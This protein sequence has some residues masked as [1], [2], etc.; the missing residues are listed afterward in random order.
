[1]GASIAPSGFIGQQ[2]SLLLGRSPAVRKIPGEQADR[3]VRVANTDNTHQ[4]QDV[5]PF[6][7]AAQRIV[8]SEGLEFECEEVLRRGHIDDQPGILSA[9]WKGSELRMIACLIGERAQMKCHAVVE[10]VRRPPILRGK[11]I[12]NLAQPFRP[13]LPKT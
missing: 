2:E 3:L 9:E 13:R 12:H 11:P 4:V 5:E 8:D 1:L 7:I 10:P 6:L